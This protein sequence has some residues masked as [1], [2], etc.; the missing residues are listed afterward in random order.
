M[1]DIKALLGRR[2]PPSALLEGT[3]A[4]LEGKKNGGGAGLLGQ[5]PAR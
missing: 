2:A 3:S 1:E 5:Q 4:L